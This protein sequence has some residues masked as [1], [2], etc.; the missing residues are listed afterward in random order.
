ME[1]MNLARLFIKPMNSWKRKLTEGPG[2]KK[3]IPVFPKEDCD[4]A[5]D[6]GT[7]FG[8][9][10]NNGCSPVSGAQLVLYQLWYKDTRYSS[11]L[12]NLGLVE[13][14]DADVVIIGRG[15]RFHRRF[16]GL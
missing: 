10:S 7:L 6:T 16:M 5:S 15:W 9:H 3:P 4:L 8:G 14:S 2:P 11:I 1:Q 12:K 13:Q